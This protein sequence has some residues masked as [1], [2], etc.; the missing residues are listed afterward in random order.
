MKPRISYTPVPPNGVDQHH[1]P[2]KTVFRWDGQSKRCPKKGEWYIS[3]AIPAAYRAPN[4]LSSEYFVCV[5]G[6]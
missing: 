5:A 6:T 3:G 1:V 2:P 4:D